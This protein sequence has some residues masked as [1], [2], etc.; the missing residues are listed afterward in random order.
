MM[1]LMYCPFCDRDNLAGRIVLETGLIAAFPS[2]MPIVDGHLLICPKRHV[3][4]I[5]ELKD[6]E[7]IG[8]KDAI[9]VLKG[10]LKKSLGAEGFNVAWNDGS[11]AG[12]VVNHMHVHLLPRKKGDK[13]SY[14]YDPRK[15]LYRPGGRETISESELAKVAAIAKS[16]LNSKE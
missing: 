13:G 7:L 14:G 12:Q 11:V 5:D 15:F 6:E 1:A 9:I 16:N 3:M 4:N 10:A 2:N 8:I